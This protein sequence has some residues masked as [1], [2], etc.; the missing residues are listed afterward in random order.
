MKMRDFE[1]LKNGAVVIIKGRKAQMEGQP[2]IGGGFGSRKEYAWA[3][4]RYVDT[5]RRVTKRHRQVELA[6]GQGPEKVVVS[7]P[8]AKLEE[9]K[10]RL[11]VCGRCGHEV[12]AVEKPQPIR[13]T[14]GHVCYFYERKEN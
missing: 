4:F 7:Q 5:K 8:T 1:N 12:M 3:T 10:Y 13:W 6:P 14:D 9:P 11:W 2:N